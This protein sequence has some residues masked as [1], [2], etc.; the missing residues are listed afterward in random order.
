MR[1][2]D[3]Y[4]SSTERSDDGGFTPRST[5]S[6]STS[7][8]NH[9]QSDSES[10]EAI[11]LEIAETR[12]EMSETVDAIQERLAPDALVEQAKEAMSEV[13]ERA[14]QEAKERAQEAIREVTEMAREAVREATVG[15][16]E[17]MI[18]NATDTAK[19][20]GESLIET[21]RANPI[22]AAIAAVSLGWLFTKRKRRGYYDA[23]YFN[24]RDYGYGE[25]RGREYG[26]GDRRGT[27][28][29]ESQ[30][31]TGKVT[32]KV[33]ETANQAGEV[34][35]DV[36]SKAGHTVSSA[37]DKVGDVAGSAG[38]TSKDIGSTVM[39]TITANPVPAAITGVGLTW[40]WMNRPSANQ[41]D[42]DTY[43][44]Y[45]GSSYQSSSQGSSGGIGEMAGQAQDKVGQ[46]AGQAQDKVGQMAGQ[47]QDT[48]GHLAGQAQDTVG[49]LTG[50]AGHQV[51]RARTS[52]E[53][54]LQENPLMVGAIAVA[55]GA[56]VGMALPSTPQEDR[57][58]GETRQNVMET[59][60]E[61]AQEVSQKVQKVA[62][63]TQSAAQ[64]AASEQKLTT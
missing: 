52:V 9:D 12:V 15:K 2:N 57:L 3:P 26:Y 34:L 31:V 63:E 25:S 5:E 14:V 11:R 35:G 51:Y 41:P 47:A 17:D 39:E 27:G 23:S 8:S 6:S 46:V 49:D 44:G 42:Y 53:G 28:Y 43:R 54:M 33:G 36:A 64:K 1:S 45:G 38:R 30:G 59:A 32:D 29:G 55:A 10:P 61:T 21:I 60:K 50:S 4:G 18:G 37:G 62:E 24:N 56:A 48:V 16:A 22:P 58:L 20:T 13:T 19:D 40:L 7:L